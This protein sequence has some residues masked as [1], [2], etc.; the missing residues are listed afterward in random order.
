MPRLWSVTA[1]SAAWLSSEESE[2]GRRR[3]GRL[4]G[5]RAQTVWLRILA[6]TYV[7]TLT[8]TGQWCLEK[9]GLRR[10]WGTCI[11]SPS[12]VPGSTWLL[13][14]TPHFGEACRLGGVHLVASIL[15]ESELPG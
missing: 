12:D 13:S 8:D 14:I 7:D 1:L 5:T 11:G 4:V 9:H 10:G 3:S 2:R 6:Q 15:A